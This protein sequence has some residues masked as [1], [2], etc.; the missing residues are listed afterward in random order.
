MIY[1]LSFWLTSLN[2]RVSRYSCIALNSSILFF[3]WGWVV[4]HCIYGD[5][6]LIHS[7]VEIYTVSMFG[8]LWIVML[9]TYG[10]HVSISIKVLS[11]YMPRNGITGL[12][13]SFIFSFLRYLHNVFHSGCTNLHSQQQWRKV[14]FLH[15]LSSICYF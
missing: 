12:Y 6:F 8:L 5:I 3:F 4:F 1:C 14:P 13:G 2:R 11:R 15:T 10:L 7:S 9:R